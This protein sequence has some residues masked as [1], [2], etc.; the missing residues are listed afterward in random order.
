VSE[1]VCVAAGRESSPCEGGV[2]FRMYLPAVHLVTEDETQY[3]YAC[4]RY[5]HLGMAVSG[6]S[7]AGM[8]LAVTRVA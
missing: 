8:S 3:V 5:D 7:Q 4:K 1:P 6:A 2:T